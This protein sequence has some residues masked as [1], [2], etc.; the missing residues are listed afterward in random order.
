MKKL[1][2]VRH[3]K[4]EDHCSGISD[5]ERSLT[6]KGKIISR[7]MGRK[8][9]EIEKTPVTIITSPAFRA[10]ETA[11]IF[12]MDFSIDPENIIIDS[13]LYHKMNLRYLPE[14]LSGAGENC[15]TVIIFGHNP[16]FTEIANNL[17]REGCDFM[18]KTGV[19]GI[20]FDIRTWPEIR[21]K[22]GKLE[23]FLKPEK[24][25]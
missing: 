5:Y 24:E 4:A 2:L 9:R 22:S 13:D 16:S 12:A 25:L 20:S 19:V 15:D 7:M 1:I 18:P 10:L 11:L 6:L 3:G 23:F 21:Q 14:I 17:C 8:L